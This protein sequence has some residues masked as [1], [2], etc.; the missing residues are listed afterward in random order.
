MSDINFVYTVTAISLP[1]D[2]LPFD[3][4]ASPVFLIVQLGFLIEKS[5]KTLANFSPILK[6]VSHNTPRRSIIL[7][8]LK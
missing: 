4:S 8:T 2:S 1:L 5:A 6:K 7:V 3:F